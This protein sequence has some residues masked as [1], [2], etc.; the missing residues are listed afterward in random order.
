MPIQ[1]LKNYHKKQNFV[2]GHLIKYNSNYKVINP[3]EYQ[4][5]TVFFILKTSRNINCKM[6]K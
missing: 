1:I 4:H 5:E 2:C 3:E 6:P